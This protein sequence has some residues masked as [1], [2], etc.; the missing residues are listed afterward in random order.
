MQTSMRIR[1]ETRDALA[2]VA[3]QELGGVTLDEALETVLF[4]RRVQ[5]QYATLMADP[6][7]YAE[8][9]AENAALAEVDVDLIDE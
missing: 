4:E 5:R 1:V 8:H 6:Q 7:A 3:E 2:E 9:L